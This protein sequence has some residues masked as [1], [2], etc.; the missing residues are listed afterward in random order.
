MTPDPVTVALTLVEE[1]D[2]VA[3]TVS[4]EG[5]VE[6]VSGSGEPVTAE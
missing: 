3:V 6:M 4:C 5:E 2:D 1:H